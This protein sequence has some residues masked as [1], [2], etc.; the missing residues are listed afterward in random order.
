LHEDEF[1]FHDHAGNVAK[2]GCAPQEGDPSASSC[3]SLRTWADHLADSE[4]DNGD[5]R[6]GE[7]LLRAYEWEIDLTKS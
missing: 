7:I 6:N 1:F 4:E 5:I 2:R 3:G